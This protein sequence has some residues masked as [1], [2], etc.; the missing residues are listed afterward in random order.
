[1]W[2][3]KWLQRREEGRGILHMVNNE[4]STEDAAAYRIFFRMSTALFQNLLDAIKADISLTDTIIF[5]FP[6]SS[7]Q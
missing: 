2:A 6:Y 5:R 7:V 1:L 3:R 4:L